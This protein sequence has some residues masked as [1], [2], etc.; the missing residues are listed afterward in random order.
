MQQLIALYLSNKYYHSYYALV[1]THFNQT[2]DSKLD[3]I[4]EVFQV[5]LYTKHGNDEIAIFKSN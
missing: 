3:N 4:C 2:Q 5:K 1:A